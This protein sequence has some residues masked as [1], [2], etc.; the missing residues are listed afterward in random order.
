MNAQSLLQ[1]SIQ[2]FLNPE[3]SVLSAPCALSPQVMS[4]PVLAKALADPTRA[5][6]L[7]ELPTGPAFPADMAEDSCVSRQILSNHLA[8]LRDWGL[9]TSKPAGRRVRYGLSN[10]RLSHA[11]DHLLGRIPTA[12]S[13]CVRTKPDCAQDRAP[14]PTQSNIAKVHP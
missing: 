13:T 11:L 2:T 8:C 6:I 5:A 7:M 4:S 12:D 10:A 1:F 9:V 14:I 3:S